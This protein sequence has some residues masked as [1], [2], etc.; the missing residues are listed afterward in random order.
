MRGYWSG[1]DGQD[2]RV[3][4]KRDQRPS[5]KTEASDGRCADAPSVRRRL[6]RIRRVRRPLSQ[7][8]RCNFSPAE[9]ASRYPACMVWFRLRRGFADIVIGSVQN[10]VTIP[11]QI[12]PTWAVI[13]SVLGADVRGRQRSRPSG[14]IRQRNTLFSS[15]SGNR[16]LGSKVQT[17]LKVTPWKDGVR[18]VMS[19]DGQW[20]QDESLPLPR[21]PMHDM[22]E[23]LSDFGYLSWYW[24][25]KSRPA[26]MSY[27]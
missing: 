17:R 1:V 8:R 18:D 19:T 6:N 10:R 7:W 4:R 5:L 27:A 23:T 24:G 13:G 3:R 25:L 9:S 21:T 11:P 2:W 26:D 12:H 16:V 14:M 20:V 15:Y 22:G